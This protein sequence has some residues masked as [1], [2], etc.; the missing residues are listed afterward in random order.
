MEP[1]AEVSWSPDC[2]HLV[3]T[4]WKYNATVVDAWQGTD[5]RRIHGEAEVSMASY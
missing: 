3:L 1:A 5:V 2:R 4:S